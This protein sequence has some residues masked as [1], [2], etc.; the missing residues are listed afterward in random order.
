MNNKKQSKLPVRV[1]QLPKCIYVKNDRKCVNYRNLPRLPIYC[2]QIL[3]IFSIPYRILDEEYVE[4][5]FK[6]VYEEEVIQLPIYK[7]TSKGFINTNIYEEV[8]II[9]DKTYT[10]AKIF[11]KNLNIPNIPKNSIAELKDEVAE[12]IETSF[13]IKFCSS[14]LSQTTK[15]AVICSYQLYFSTQSINE[16]YTEH[17]KVFRLIDYISKASTNFY[18]VFANQQ[19]YR[20]KEIDLVITSKSL[21]SII[22]YN[23]W[24]THYWAEYL[25]AKGINLIYS[26]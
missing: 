8:K 10:Q 16:F 20:G 18:V 2:Q 19:S 13:F 25:G 21:I 23:S 15:N 9:T 5:W 1:Q 24:Q 7:W 22:G 6:D 12:A 14:L 26:P 3:D 17:I 4:Y 11:E